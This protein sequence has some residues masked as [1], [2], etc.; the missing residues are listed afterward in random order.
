MLKQEK[1]ES[2]LNVVWSLSDKE[3]DFSEHRDIRN[4]LEVRADQAVRG[5]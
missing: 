5:A 4:V 3:K 2:R 1:I